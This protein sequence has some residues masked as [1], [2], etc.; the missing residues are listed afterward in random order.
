MLVVPGSTGLAAIEPTAALLA[1]HG[2]L[3]LVAA[4]MQE[5]GLPPAMKEI[6]VELIG[7]ALA[8]LDRWP[9]RRPCSARR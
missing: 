6:P 9:V 3:A 5:P 7:A 1:S 4:Y 2:Y 8:K